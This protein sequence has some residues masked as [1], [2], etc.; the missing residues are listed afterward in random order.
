MRAIHEKV[1]TMSTH[2]SQ[3]LAP[4]AVKTMKLKNHI[5]ELYLKLGLNED[6][7]DYEMFY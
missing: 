2:I 6:A 5:K 1:K 4:A 3:Q 7:A